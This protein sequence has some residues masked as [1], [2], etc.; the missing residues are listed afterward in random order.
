[1][2]LE[3]AAVRASVTVDEVKAAIDTAMGRRPG[4]RL[5]QG[6]RVMNVITYD[7]EEADVLLAGRLIAGVGA[8]FAHAD[9]EETVDLGGCWLVPGLIDGHVHLESS[10]VAPAEYARAVVPRGVTGVACDPHEIA[11][12]AG[13]AGIGWLIDASRGLPLDVWVTIPSC[14]PSSPLETSGAAIGLTEIADLMDHPRVVGVA[15][16]MDIAGVTAGNEEVLAKALVSE[17]FRKVTEGHV[18]AV[19]GRHL[20]A[21]LAA[22]AASDHESTT[23]AEGLEKLRAGCFLMVREGSVSRNLDALVPLLRSSFADRIGFVTDDRFPNDLLDEGG[24]DFLVRRAIRLGIPP[25]VAVRCGSW[26]TARHFR[27]P[28]RGAI[29]PG[30][31]ADLAVVDDIERFHVRAVYKGGRA[32]AADGRVQWAMPPLPQAGAA[33]RGSVKLPDI[34]VSSFRLGAAGTRVR[35]IRLVPGQLLTEQIWIQP[36]C[37]DGTAVADPERDLAK[38]VCVERHGTRG[39]TGVGLVTGFGLRGGALASTV[40]H[41]HH[42]LMAVGMQDGDLLVACRRLEALGGGFVAVSGGRILAELPLP[43]GGLMTDQPLV[44]VRHDLDALD[45]AARGLG[46]SVP[47]PFMI[48]SFLGLAVIPEL[49]LTDFGL[50]DVVAARVVPLGAEP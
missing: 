48:L 9:A 18:P 45:E 34:S 41:D 5:L 35:C 36:R 12:V 43:L 50:V 15:E 1:M 23:L 4:T 25:A 13:T 37:V 46:V 44:R 14:V 26:N 24:V 27:L 42:N 11:N 8:A 39:G 20:A 10:L 49:R 32:A 22:G 17:M 33:M 30:Y 28:R 29:A 2:T 3:P 16:L 31:V 21:Y 19:G 7:I 6:A 38:L 47:S 40:A